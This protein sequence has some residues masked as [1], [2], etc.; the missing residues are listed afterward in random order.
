MTED[1]TYNVFE[2]IKEK[3][4]RVGEELA[5]RFLEGDGYFYEWE[6]INTLLADINKFLE[7]LTKEDDIDAKRE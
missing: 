6:A 2:Y 1:K 7:F 4:E 3:M 5:N